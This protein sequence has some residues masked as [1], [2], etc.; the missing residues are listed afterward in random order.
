MTSKEKFSG[1]SEHYTKYRPGYPNEVFDFLREEIGINSDSI[2][3]DIG[4]GTGI[5]T[6]NIA[7]ICKK[8]YAVEP[9]DDMRKACENAAQAYENIE[10]IN[11]SAE[12]TTL[13]E[14][15]IDFITVAQSFHWFDHQKTKME[16][17]RILKE[18]AYV[19]LIWNSR[20][21]RHPFIIENDA[22]FRRIC[23]NYKGF[24]GGTHEDDTMFSSFFRNGE[25]LYKQFDNHL[26]FDLEGFL[27]RNL[28]ASYAP[29]EGE[30]SY[31]LFIT[32]LTAL[33]NKY[34][35]D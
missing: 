34:S 5:F 15:S 31:D 9:N 18:D 19:L 29:L 1:K 10:I 24:S 26:S 27:G 4:A 35:I 3:A 7:A 21:N 14:K 25:Y 20:D 8:V 32:E 28:S 13:A 17:Q 22:L 2:V 6:K 16:C 11:G 33:F 23:P 12:N 30:E